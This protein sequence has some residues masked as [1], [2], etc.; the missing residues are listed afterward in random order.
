MPVNRTPRGQK[1]DFSW[2]GS[3]RFEQ[4]RIRQEDLEEAIDHYDR[5]EYDKKGNIR[6]TKAMPD[7]RSLRIHIA[8]DT[9]PLRIITVRII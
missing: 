8:R 2:H 5:S 3:T 1:Y 9:D 4:R 7:G 6:L